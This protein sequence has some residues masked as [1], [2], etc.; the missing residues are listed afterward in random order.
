MCLM[1]K[2]SNCNDQCA[3]SFVPDSFPYFSDRAVFLKQRPLVTLEVAAEMTE[4]V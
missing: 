2:R 3:L 1:I 4:V